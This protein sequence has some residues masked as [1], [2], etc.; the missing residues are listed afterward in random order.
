M[1]LRWALECNGLITS[2]I[3]SLWRVQKSAVA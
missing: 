1:A 2:V 3:E